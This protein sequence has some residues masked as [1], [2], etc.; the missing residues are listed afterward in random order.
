MITDLAV[1]RP[2]GVDGE[3]QL[4]SW[5]PGTTPEIVRERTG[6]ALG[7]LPGAGETRPPTEDELGALR[8]IDKDG[9]WRR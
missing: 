2:A 6:W 3:L 4:A 7:L 9:F 5:H 8:R 1:L